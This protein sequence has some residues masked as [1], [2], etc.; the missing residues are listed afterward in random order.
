MRCRCERAH[1]SPE[2][3]YLRQTARTNNAAVVAEN[4]TKPTSVYSVTR[5]EESLQVIAHLS[6][7]VPR[8]WFVDN[9]LLQG[10]LI[11]ELQY[12]LRVAVEAKVLADINA[13][14]GAQ[15]Q[16]FATSPL[17]TVRKSI[18]KLEANGYDPAAIVL[19]PA[20]WEGIELALSSTNAVEHLSLPYD[21]AARRLYGV[22]VVVPTVQ[23]VGV[24]HTLARGAVAVDT[25]NQGAGVQWSEN[26]N[27]TDFAQNLMRARVEG[28]Y[29]TSVYNPLGVVVGDLTA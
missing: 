14:S 15:A 1:V 26:S 25:D 7:G 23:A 16:A 2:F 6:E 19:S 17:V 21:P 22:P 18:T 12:G 9:D 4:G 29:A 20:D 27:A 10:F 5:I 24:S 8:Y 11:N 13:A 3:S 28:R